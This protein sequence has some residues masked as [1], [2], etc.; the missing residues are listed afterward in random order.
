MTQ[1]N[2]EVTNDGYSSEQMAGFRETFDGVESGS[3]PNTAL[4]ELP[5]EIL[6]QVAAGEGQIF[7]TEEGGLEKS[8]NQEPAAESAT[9]PEPEDLNLKYKNKADEANTWKQKYES[10]N[11]KHDSEMDFELKLQD[12]LFR[13]KYFEDKGYVSQ[14]EIEDIDLT[15]PLDEDGE[16]DFYNEDY[17]KRMNQAL[18]GYTKDQK[19]RAE[20]ER[21]ETQQTLRSKEIDR[22]FDEINSLQE[23]YPGLKTE[24]SF[25]E[26]D[27][28]FIDFKKKLGSDVNKYFEDSD[29]RSAKEQD[30]I[31]APSDMDKYLTLLN[32][33]SRKAKY[34]SLEAAFRDSDEFLSHIN[35]RTEQTESK[36]EVDNKFDMLGATNEL[37]NELAPMGQGQSGGGV[38]AS[39]DDDI[40]FMERWAGREHE[41]SESDDKQY[42]SIIA[43]MDAKFGGGI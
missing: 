8:S 10:L 40:A 25:R 20:R 39:D 3:L 17:L 11:R 1:E 23:K 2:S 6:D 15:V 29:F 26:L 5:M 18:V 42:N 7:N 35:N 9:T 24:K 14:E 34:P 22:T 27:T 33:N 38:E 36:P 28:E 4:E 31:V 19:A 12:P 21:T 43:R 30:G 41:M 32:I 13:K 37:K 16:P